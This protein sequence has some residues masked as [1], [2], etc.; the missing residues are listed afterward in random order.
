MF[1]VGT[2]VKYKDEWCSEGERKY[3]HIIKEQRLNPV[4]N[5][6]TRYLIETINTTLTLNPT[7]VVDECMITKA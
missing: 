4:T 1:E 7:S 2:I 3:R 5:E 6:M